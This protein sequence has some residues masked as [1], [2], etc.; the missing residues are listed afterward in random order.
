MPPTIKIKVVLHTVIDLDGN[1]LEGTPQFWSVPSEDFAGYMISKEV[2]IPIIVCSEESLKFDSVP[3]AAP[4]TELNIHNRHVPKFTDKNDLLG[5]YKYILS[6]P[7]GVLQAAGV[8]VELDEE[9]RYH[10]IDLSERI[11]LCPNCQWETVSY[12]PEEATSCVSCG[13]KFPSS[14]S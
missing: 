9:E 13:N 11:D 4:V 2:E 8:K 14:S 6:E 1:F 10:I 3:C 5:Y 7:L 12:S